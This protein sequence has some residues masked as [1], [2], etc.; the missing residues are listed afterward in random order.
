MRKAFT[1][2]E[3][4]ASTALAALL[5]LAILKVVASLG[6]SRAALAHQAQVQPWRADLVETLRRDLSNAS[7]ISFGPDSVTLIS[8]AS[9]DSLDVTLGHQP[10]TVVYGL[11]TL[12]GRRWLVRRQSSRDTSASPSAFAELLC[13][14]VASFNIHPAGAIPASRTPVPVPAILIVS[15]NDSSGSIVD[16]TLVLR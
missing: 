7:Q 15:I 3:L 2:L 14:D 4:L 16:Q 13:S 11:S 9:L 5:M 8:H 12:H 1:L 10:V 6:A